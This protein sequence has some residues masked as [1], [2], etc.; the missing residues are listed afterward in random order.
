M[1]TVQADKLIINSNN[2]N[3]QN[4]N[5]PNNVI[6]NE[7]IIVSYFYGCCLT[8][9]YIT[10]SIIFLWCPFYLIFFGF[11]TPYKRIV[12]I[13]E[14][15]KVLIIGSKGIVGC[16]FFDETTYHLSQIKKVRIFV[17]WKPDPKI[18][19]N[20]LYFINCEIYSLTDEKNNLF[21][22]V[23][24]EEGKFNQFVAFFQRHV[25]IEF[26]PIE[27]AISAINVIPVDGN[28]TIFPADN[29]APIDQAIAKPSINESAALPIA[30]DLNP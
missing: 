30:S 1:E 18:G 17:T 21:V 15:R 28:N 6:A 14:E 24:Y 5:I 12:T 20:K 7:Q 8:I 11:F 26:E 3:N 22:D 10:V 13:D 19:F 9:L 23:P 16:C 27:N 25:N 29:Q 2:L 4:N